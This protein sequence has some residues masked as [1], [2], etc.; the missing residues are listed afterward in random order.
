MVTRK[1][2]KKSPVSASPRYSHQIDRCQG[3][4]V[5]A[6]GS[7]W[8]H[9]SDWWNKFLIII[10]SLP[11]MRMLISPLSEWHKLSPD[12]CG[13]TSPWIN[14]ISD[15]VFWIRKNRKQPTCWYHPEFH[16]HHHTHYIPGS[17]LVCLS[18][19]RLNSWTAVGNRQE[20]NWSSK[21]FLK[22]HTKRHCKWKYSYWWFSSQVKLPNITSDS[23]FYC[24]CRN[25]WWKVYEHLW[26]L[27][28]LEI[29][30]T[31]L[32]PHCLYSKVVNKQMALLIESDNRRL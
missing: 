12:G 3:A 28:L 17:L 9:T 20:D 10:L 13:L 1:N 32:N 4:G 8:P 23:Y 25:N 21:F 26:I 24:L 27:L 18:L 5:R 29:F 15:C 6:M 2:H 22:N 7:F 31:P 30:L 14:Y 16:H 11:S 19:S